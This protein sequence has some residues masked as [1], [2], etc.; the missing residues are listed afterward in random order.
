MKH[1]QAKIDH[2]HTLFISDLHLDDNHPQR[3][4]AFVEFLEYKACAAD[5]LYILGDL[6]EVWIGDDAHSVTANTVQS[7]LLS[8]TQTGFP[9]Y[10][11]HGN[12][13][14]LLGKRFA[15]ATGCQLIK[16]PSIID[17][18]GTP[19]LLLHGDTLCTHDEIYQ[20]YRRRMRNPMT[21]K[22]IT[23]I[24]KLARQYIA[25]K[26]RNNSK[27]RNQRVDSRLM[28]IHEPELLNKLCTYKLQQVIHG[29]THRPS[30]RYFTH[31][32]HVVDG[33]LACQIVLSDWDS[34]ANYLI[35]YADGRK[36]LQYG[37]PT[38]TTDRQQLMDNQAVDKQ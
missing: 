32:Q 36:R 21:L 10:V 22:L 9:I 2:K 31:Q 28:D 38:S 24:P 14:F 27:K 29:H 19:T 23:C 33:G 6:F 16:D 8:L 15:A 18:Y 4:L 35:Y 25:K 30:I 11:M 17:L 3:T 12:R 37:Q 34:R 26:M 1:N 20:A 5:A 13:D 7:V